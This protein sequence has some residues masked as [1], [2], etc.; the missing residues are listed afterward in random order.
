MRRQILFYIAITIA[1]VLMWFS[2]SDSSEIKTL[3]DFKNSAFI[4]KYRQRRQMD[5]WPLRDGAYA[6]SF[7]FPLGSSPL[8]D[9]YDWFS[10]E[11]IAKSKNNPT[12][13]NFGI[14]FHDESAPSGPTRFNQHIREI[15]QD[16]ISSFDSNLPL[17]NI[18]DYV[19]KQSVVKYKQI[20]DAPK[21][22]FGKYF[23]RVGVV[24]HDLIV[25]ID[26]PK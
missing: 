7:A 11:M 26:K 10:V 8:Y 25:D 15:F 17:K 20:L 4:K 3:E 5:S 1:S 18:A 14:M 24:G 6:Y 19:E 23:L 21:K 2:I 22:T 12:I 13:Y 9:E 16:F